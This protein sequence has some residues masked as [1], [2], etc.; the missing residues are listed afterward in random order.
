MWHIPNF[1]TELL[2]EVTIVNQ[3]WYYQCNSEKLKRTFNK[4]HMLD[5]SH[6]PRRL[7]LSQSWTPKNV[8]YDKKVKLINDLP[9]GHTCGGRERCLMLGSNHCGRAH[10]P[11]Y[12][13]LYFLTKIFG[14]TNVVYF[15]QNRWGRR[16]ISLKMTLPEFCLALLRFWWLSLSRDL[17]EK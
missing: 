12:S 1:L 10:L 9:P 15:L 6:F 3:D 7:C 4:S 13:F 16:L 14:N 17:A 11:K 5:S 2:S 8:V